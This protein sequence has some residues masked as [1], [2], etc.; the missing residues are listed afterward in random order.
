MT[1]M[2]DRARPAATGNAGWMRRVCYGLG[3]IRA[4]KFGTLAGNG[5]EASP[6]WQL[7]RFNG[8]LVLMGRNQTMKML[9][10]ATNVASRQSLSGA[11]PKTG[12]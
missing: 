11:R 2:K 5:M 12:R 6:T 9:I 3:I 10:Q 7:G 8:E 4:G 1:E